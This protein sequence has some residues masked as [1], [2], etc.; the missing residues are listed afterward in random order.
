[1][2]LYYFPVAPNPTRVLVYLGE[3]G[4]EDI[5]RVPVDLRQGEQNAEAHLARNPEGSLPVLELDNGDYLT[6]SLP[7]IEYIEELY[8]E[9]PLIG[10]DADSRAYARSLERKAEMQLLGP[11][12]RLVHA[13]NSPLGLPVNEAVAE[14]ERARLPTSFERFNKTIADRPFVAGDTP[15][16]ADC[17]LFAALQFG[18]FFGVDI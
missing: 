3:K 12:A 13:T 4:I 1:M 18:Q 10:T 14:I 16:I 15:T 2:K 8:P 11:V 5:E 7:I 6:E 9:P 17:T